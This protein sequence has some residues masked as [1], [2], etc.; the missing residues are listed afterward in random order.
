MHPADSPEIQEHKEYKQMT[1][2]R[3]VLIVTGGIAAYKSC[4]LVRNIV[5]AGGQVQV[6]MTESAQEFIKPLTFSTLS[7]RLVLSNLFPDPS[8]SEPI[9]LQSASWSEILV[10]APATA[11]FIGK[12]ANGIAD[13][14]ASSIAMSFQD[15]IL[16]APA[17]NPRMWQNSVVQL[18]VKKLLEQGVEIIGPEMG[19]MAGFNEDLGFG[20]MSEPALIFNRIEELLSDRTRWR[21]R[22]VLVTSG[23]T[24]EPIDPVRFISNHSSGRMGDAVARQAFLRGAEVTLIRGKG[25]IG[26]PPAGINVVEV[27]TASEMTAEVKKRFVKSDMLVMTAAVSDWTVAN[28]SSSKLKKRA[29]FPDLQWEQTEDILAWAGKNRTHQVI[30]GFALETQQY[31]DNARRKLHEKRIDMIALNDPTQSHSAFGGETIQLTLIPRVGESRELPLCSKQQ[32]A[33][34]LLDAAESFFQN[35]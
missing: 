17:M 19:E 2:R 5:H 8:P 23:P 24:R 12:L 32:A 28:V 14:L 15:K 22:N 26:S 33:D 31:A 21:D 11:N 13:D 7:G 25:A 29:G 9:H 18:N 3:I 35:N 16:I 27:D 6:V 30:I 34:K 10:T 4:T 20:R 1:D